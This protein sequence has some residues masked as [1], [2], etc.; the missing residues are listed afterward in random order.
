[1]NWKAVT[2]YEGIYEVSECGC[3]RSLDRQ[4]FPKAGPTYWLKGVV[5]KQCKN[6][7]GYFKLSL[8][9]NNKEKT[10]ETHRLVMMAFVGPCP[11]GMEIR[12]LD[13]TRDNNHVDNLTYGTLSE[14]QQDRKTHGTACLGENSP[15]SKLTDVQCHEIV[16]Q[17]ATGKYT[18]REVGTQ[19]GVT[20]GNVCRVVNGQRGL[21]DGTRVPEKRIAFRRSG[22]KGANNGQVKS[23]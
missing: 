1:M 9:K 4:I 10:F 21:V 2:R 7:R 8:F 16:D 13:G 18:M 17:Y 19:F 12:H 14:N 15:V 23:S 5:H 6:R 11:E 20:A 3:V 22:Q